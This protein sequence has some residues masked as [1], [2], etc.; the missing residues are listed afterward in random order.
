MAQVTKVDQYTVRFTFAVPYF[1]FPNILTNRNVVAP[2]HYLKQFHA[3]YVGLDK[4]NQMAKEADVENW[5]QLFKHTTQVKLNTELPRVTPWILESPVNSPQYNAVR[6]PYYHGVDPQGNQL[7][8][9]DRIVHDL[10]LDKDVLN[11]KAMAGEIDMQTRHIKF[12]NYSL[13]KENEEE[14]DYRVVEWALPGGSQASFMISQTY[15]EDPAIGELLQNRDFRIGL[16][17]AINRDAIN[18]LVYLGT[19]QARQGAPPPDNPYY[20]GDEYALKYTQYDTD[21]ANQ[22]LDKALPNKNAAGFRLLPDGRVAHP[23]GGGG[24][25]RHRRG[26]RTCAE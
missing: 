24:P 3:S 1:L 2:A 16:S 12:A 14:G 10:V 26:G 22:F 18:D 17:H 23:S 20:P 11:L 9:I 7:P 19:G 5:V 15:V 4:L 21:T 13:F 6:N 8:Y 25:G